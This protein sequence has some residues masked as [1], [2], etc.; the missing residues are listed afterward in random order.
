MKWMSGGAKR[1]CDRALWQR[2]LLLAWRTAI[3]LEVAAG[4]RREAVVLAARK[5]SGW[6]KMC[7]L[8][9]TFRWECSYKKRNGW[10]KFWA[11]LASFSPEAAQQI[12]QIYL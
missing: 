6:P 5:A 4:Q 8:A 9:H 10:P 11:N 7:K 3:G 1:Q 2:A 12:E